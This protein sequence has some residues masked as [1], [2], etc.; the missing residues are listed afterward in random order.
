MAKLGKEELFDLV[1]GAVRN[2]GWQ[3]VRL[4]ALNQ[5]PLR[6]KM[7]KDEE[8]LL[9]RAYIWNISHGGGAA[10][11]ADEYR[12][13]ITG[14][15]QFREE[16]DGKTVILGWWDEAGVFAG[17]DFRFHRRPLGFSPSFQIK[18][19]YLREA[20]QKGFCPYQ[21]DNR[22]IAVAF[23][24]DFIAEYLRQLESLHGFGRQ[25]RDFKILASVAEDPSAVSDEKITKVSG[26]RRITVSS[27]KR[28]LRDTYFKD[29][30]L[31]AY[32]HQCAICGLQLDLVEAAHIIPVAHEQSSDETSNGMAMCAIHHKAY[33]KALIAVDAKYRILASDA[34]MRFLTEIGHDGGRE[35]FLRNLRPL[36]VLPPAERDRP[37]PGYLKIGMEIRG[38]EN[39]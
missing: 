5:H 4:S 22:E 20:Y 26:P 1:I 27:V 38:W 17:F 29:R 19:E 7:F 23:R 25:S 16:P 9:V 6:F 32:R 13:Q 2:C 33:D 28:F 21:K 31:N 14:V 39:W 3:V 24:P 8:G 34:R 12:I 36:M 15:D 18:E 37:N 11:P 10:R 35:N 30:V